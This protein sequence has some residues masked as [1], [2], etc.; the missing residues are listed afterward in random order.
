MTEQQ[1]GN[2]SGDGTGEEAAAEAKAAADAKA[3]A[4]AKSEADAKG[5][6]PKDYIIERAKARQEKLEK[7]L[8]EARKETS[9]LT[10]GANEPSVE[11]VVEARLQREDAINSYLLE[12]PELADRK[13]K[14]K[15][16]AR[17]TGKTGTPIEEIV[18][19]AIGAG[20]F[21]KIGQEREREAQRMAAMGRMGGG[22]NPDMKGKTQEDIISDKY[23]A[24]EP[25]FV[26]E[27][28]KI[29]EKNNS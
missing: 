15:E 29:V 12:Y 8:E 4:D 14:I 1:P 19:G 21:L 27:A 10:P 24:S 3:L 23:A 2:G 22:T 26:T 18:I 16:F 7:E 5:K 20:E 28:R 9:L 13:D 25:K 11:D 6:D 17:M